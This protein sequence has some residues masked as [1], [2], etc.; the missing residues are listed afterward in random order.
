MCNARLLVFQDRMDAWLCFWVTLMFVALPT[1]RSTCTCVNGTLTAYETSLTKLSDYSCSGNYRSLHTIHLANNNLHS[2]EGTGLSDVSGLL[3]LVVA[4]N[5]LTSLDPN[6]L[7]NLTELIYLDLSYNKLESFKN[8]QL[9]ASQSRLQILILSHNRIVTLHFRVLAPLRGLQKLNLSD[10][11][12]CCD[13]ELRHTVE[14]C[15]ER[16]LSTGAVCENGVPWTGISYENCTPVTLIVTGIAIGIVIIAA[17]VVEVWV[18][19]LRR[20]RHNTFDTE[21]SSPEDTPENLALQYCQT[22]PSNVRTCQSSCSTQ[23]L[24]FQPTDTSSPQEYVLITQRNAIH[25]PETGS[26]P[27][28]EAGVTVSPTYAE[29]Y[30]YT[31]DASG[32]YAVPYYHTTAKTAEENVLWTEW[33]NEMYPADVSV[34]NSLYSQT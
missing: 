11:P 31:T 33:N 26:N 23:S 30:Q 32:T 14:W 19:C 8:E 25:H 21:P 5:L 3:Y 29:P 6:L 15:A 27:G 17:V 12:F 18:C 13:C 2:L 9:F 7:S 1:A 4:H 24:L 34:R 10:N 16:N 22:R 28:T 20:A